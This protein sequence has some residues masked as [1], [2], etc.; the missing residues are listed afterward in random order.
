[1]G[2]IGSIRPVTGDLKTITTNQ[3]IDQDGAT[4]LNLFSFTSAM[5]IVKLSG[6]I[7]T[8]TD[9]TSCTGVSFVLY[10]GTNTVQI[11]KNDGVLTS[12]DVGSI[13]YKD[14]S[15]ATTFELLQADQV[16]LDETLATGM[17][18]FIVN[19][20]TGV[21]NY[22]QFNYTGATGFDINVD[23]YCEYLPIVPG[24]SMAVV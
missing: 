1:M 5:H 12:M 21:T 23:F 9:G 7:K 11:T 20:K 2:H 8:V 15:A 18:E 4:T 19:P 13:F 14:A 24:T 17:Y 6:V 22:I 3:D 16:R 10:D